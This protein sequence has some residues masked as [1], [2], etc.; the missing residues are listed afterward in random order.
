MIIGLW[1]FGLGMVFQICRD[2]SRWFL[3]KGHKSGLN[4]HMGATKMYQDLKGIFWWSGM[5]KDVMEFVYSGLVCQDLRIEHQSSASV[6]WLGGLESRMNE[7]YP[8]LF[9][10]G[11]LSKTKIK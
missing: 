2:L 5:K 9:V 7:S 1:D 4:I 6:A 3:E 11:K 8:G 10:L